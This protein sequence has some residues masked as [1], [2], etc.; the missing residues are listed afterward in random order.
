MVI[1]LGTE[2]VSVMKHLLR[3]RMSV[4]I[5]SNSFLILLFELLTP[6]GDHLVH[7][8]LHHLPVHYILQDPKISA[9]QT[10]HPSPPMMGKTVELI[11][12]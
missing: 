7:P 11:Y 10:D 1:Y 4:Y 3:A 12:F 5:P 6:I 9:F 8:L 2:Y